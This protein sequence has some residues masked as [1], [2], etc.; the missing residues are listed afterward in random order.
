MGFHVGF[1]NLIMA[2]VKLVSF[3]VTLN[4]KVG[5]YFKPSRELRQGDP[6][7]SYLF[8]FISEVFSSLIVHTLY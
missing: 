5:E 8:L 4:G 3:A 2:C 7:S 6:I 1:V